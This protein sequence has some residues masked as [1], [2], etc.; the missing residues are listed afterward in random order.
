MRLRREGA[1][2]VSIAP[3]WDA[4]PIPRAIS[5]WASRSRWTHRSLRPS[6]SDEQ[7]DHSHRRLPAVVLISAQYKICEPSRVARSG[8]KQRTTRSKSFALQWSPD[9]SP[10]HHSPLVVRTYIRFPSKTSELRKV[11]SELR[12]S[13]LY[14]RPGSS[15]IVVPLSLLTKSRLPASV[16]LG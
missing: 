5:I 1:A 13:S 9:Y 3:R 8:R 4:L 16:M 10:M 12:A 7:F 14:S 2:Q 6:W 15:T 11:S